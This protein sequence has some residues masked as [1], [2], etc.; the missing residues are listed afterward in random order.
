MKPRPCVAADTGLEAVAAI[1]EQRKR[2]AL[3]GLMDALSSA[4]AAE[5]NDD[6][7]GRALV[8]LIDAD[9]RVVEA[10]RR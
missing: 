5:A 7:F 2:Q 8:E 1:A 4:E 10:K 9:K 6:E 3:D